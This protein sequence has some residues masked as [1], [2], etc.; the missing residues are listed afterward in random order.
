MSS[1]A[2][3]ILIITRALESEADSRDD[4]EESPLKNRSF[5][6]VQKQPS[7]LGSFWF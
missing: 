6:N 4:P 5:P 3:K 7:E 2:I 1:G